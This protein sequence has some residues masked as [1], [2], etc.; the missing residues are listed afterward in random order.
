MKDLTILAIDTS[1][2]V[3]SAALTRD[4]RLLGEVSVVT[5]LTHSQVILPMV[6]RL[7]DDCETDI[8]EIDI[9]AAANG[10]GSY[11]G[12][13]I[14]IGAV[15]GMC[16]GRKSLK[17]AGVSTLLALAYN[18]SAF[19][20]YIY[21]AIKARNSIC[22]FAAFSSQSGRISRIYDDALTELDDIQKLIRQNGGR[23]MVT[24][25][26]AEMIKERFTDDDNV[27][28]APENQRI[29]R[30]SSICFAVEDDMSLTVPPEEL[31][32]SYLQPT[33]AQKDRAHREEKQQTDV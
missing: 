30:A 13:R 3:A 2:K 12:L 6:K 31:G 21:T 4:G 28:T 26:A 23:A 17:C 10:P 11:T 29:A 22:Y 20:G 24:G 19:E 16:L 33:K 5:R 8:N 32:V 15:K 7:L 27:M 9:A 18:L 1:G 14:G 25:D